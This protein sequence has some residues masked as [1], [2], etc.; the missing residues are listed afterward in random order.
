LLPFK[1]GPTKGRYAPDCGRSRSATDAPGTAASLSRP[2]QC[3]P[4]FGVS[5]SAPTNKRWPSAAG[6]APLR[7]AFA[8]PVH[9]TFGQRSLAG[10]VASR[11]ERRRVAQVRSTLSAP[12]RLVRG[13]HQPLLLRPT[14][15]MGQEA[16]SSDDEDG[17]ELPCLLIELALDS[18]THDS[19]MGYPHCESSSCESVVLKARTNTLVSVMSTSSTTSLH[20]LGLAISGLPSPVNW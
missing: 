15:A 7:F 6:N 5:A 4:S 20:G 19:V 14:K 13:Q 11:A 10:A 8:W 16:R 2:V 9:V 1:I 17:L 18:V 12:L 3:R